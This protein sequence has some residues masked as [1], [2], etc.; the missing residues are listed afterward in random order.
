MPEAE[1]PPASPGLQVPGLPTF[2]ALSFGALVVCVGSGVVLMT[3]FEPARPVLSTLAFETARPF[4]WFFRALHAWSAQLFLVTLIV[5][6]IN[7]VARRADRQ[8]AFGAWLAVVATLPL[9]IF[10]MLGGRALVGDVEGQG[11]AA[12]LHGIV[13]ALPWV[14]RPLG[15]ML[16]GTEPGGNAHLLLTHHAATGTLL[17]C[18]ATFA[19]LRRV[20]PDAATL[21]AALGLAGAVALVVRPELGALAEGARL[22]GP[23]FMGGLRLSLQ[24]APVWLAGLALPAVAFGALALLPKLS[25][26]MARRTRWTLAALALGYGA[27]TVVSLW[28]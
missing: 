11:V 23:W 18:A 13:S 4:G 14:G 12:V 10:L 26:A 22:R 19:H 24:Q 6:T 21:A 16:V 2:G 20:V 5:H 9:T 28:R 15:E 8:T 1:R 17:L 27:L 7:Y 3:G 25:D